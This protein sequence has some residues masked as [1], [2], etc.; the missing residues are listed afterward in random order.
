[1]A[2]GHD[3]QPRHL[4]Q[5]SPLTRV[6]IVL[7]LVASVQ[8]FVWRFTAT[9]NP[10]AV[11]FFFLFLAAELVGFGEV[12][13]FYLT[14]WRQGT[15]RPPPPRPGHSVD[16]F[17]PTYNE[18]VSLLRDTVVCAV[19]MKYPHTTWIL[20]DG[21]RPE[22]A[23][24]AQELGCEYLARA[25]RSH[26]KAG[27][28]NHGLA[29]SRGQFVVTLDADHVPMPDLIEQLLG[30]FED[31]RVAIVQ[32]NQDFYNLDSFQHDTDWED[33]AA[34]QQQELFFNVIQPGKDAFNAAMYCGSPA[35][36]RRAALEEVG[37]FATETVTEDMHTG[38]RL[39]MRGW[40]VIYYNR[41]VARGLAPQT[42][43]AYNTQW[44]R[45]GLGAMQ[46]LRLERPLFRKGLTLGQRLCYL[47]SFYF[48][49]TSF[50]KVFYLLVPV[51]SVATA[52]FPLL[53]QPEAYVRHFL[54]YLGL[55][56]LATAALQG[57]WHGFVLTERYNLIKLGSMMRSV[58]GFFRRRAQFAVTPKARGAAAAF[59]HVLPYMVLEALLGLAVAGGVV[60]IVSART[61]FEF[62]AY[63]VNVFFAL[64]FLFLMV[65]VVILALKRKE[66]RAIYRFPQR[67]DLP[68]RYRLFGARESAWAES[69][70]RNL[71]RFGL[72]I[73]LDVALPQETALELVVRLPE[74]DV[75]AVGTVR[76]STEFTV[77]K[78]VRHANGLRF[79][80]ITVED[81]DAIARHI[82]WEIAPRHGELMTMTRRAQLATVEA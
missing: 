48:Y 62:W 36:L 22:V 42:F 21:N 23:Q 26:A 43:D 15:H 13:L 73:T 56:L 29:R 70:A 60:R 49:W 58:A 16:V 71:N 67:L 45:W 51:F 61:M 50:Q 55:N 30:L 28:L 76:W 35:M 31:P 54:P 66:L 41:T 14:T 33:R 20:D 69:Y 64:F 40:R 75:H 10:A 74:R 32:A 63:G 8:Y 53:T 3:Q 82:F 38:L 37:G 17:I 25:D 9:I 47:A 81:Q 7:A 6:V 24:L 34:W 18:P 11:W 46:V 72:S 4:H 78:R 68:I 44:H 5:P 27:N 2:T 59:R 79:D 65:P 77:D 52:T 39:Q 12:V 80:R 19:S 1:V 57:G